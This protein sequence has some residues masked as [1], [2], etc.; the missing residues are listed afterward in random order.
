M[1]SPGFWEF[2]GSLNP[3]ETLR[4]YL[5]DRHERSKDRK[6]REAAEAERMRLENERLKIEVVK[7]QVEVLRK[8]GVAE[9]RI[10]QALTRHLVE[11]LGQVDR[12]QDVGMIESAELRDDET[13][14]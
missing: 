11:P 14:P 12:F 2:A 3:L 6:Y 13:K 9:D 8:A 5:S 10:R 1:T 4:K 7:E